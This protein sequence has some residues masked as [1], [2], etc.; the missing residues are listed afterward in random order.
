MISPDRNRRPEALLE[1]SS[2]AFS[3]AEAAALAKRL[4]GCDASATELGSERDQNFCLTAPDGSRQ[5]LKIANPAE[6]PESLRFENEAMQHIAAVAPGFPV[7]RI[8][9]ALDGEAMAAVEHAGRCC[10][11]RMISWLPGR[12]LRTVEPT[13]ALRRQLG[14]SLAELGLALRGFFHPAA[15]KELLWDI[16]HTGALG[17]WLEYVEDPATRLLCARVV[18]GFARSTL[19]KLATLRSQVIHNDFH[20]SNVLVSD[21]DPPTFAGAVDFGDM[22]HAPLVCDVAVGATYQSAAHGNPLDGVVDFVAGYHRV[23]PL[24][25]AEIDLIYELICARRATTVVVMSWQASRNPENSDYLLEDVVEAAASLEELSGMGRVEA[26]NILQRACRPTRAP[27]QQHASGD[28]EDL[29]ARRERLLGPA[30]RLFYEEPV[31]ITRGEGV[32]LYGADGRAY[33]DA[34]NNVP[35]VGHCHP[36]VVNA[37]CE[38][39]ATLNTHTRYLHTTVLDY[40]ERLL[41]IFPDALDRVMFSCTGTEANELALRIARA[42]S[43]NEGVIVSE[44]AYHGNSTAIAALSPSDEA[45]EGLPNWIETIPAPDTY[46]DGPNAGANFL[47]AMDAAIEQLAKRGI[48]PAAL[49]LDAGFTSDG[50]FVA[51]DGCLRSAAEKIRAA[52]GL[53]IADEV[54]SGFARLGVALWGFEAHG[55][56]PDIVTL[57]KPIGNG[58]PLAATITS[59]EIVREFASRGSYFNTFGGNPVSAAVGRAVLDAF[60]EDELEEN[61]RRVG[62]YLHERLAA[63]RD[64]H[65]VIGDV[66]GSGL[67][68]GVELVTDR[69]TRQPA[70]DKASQVV[71]D[72]RRHGVLISTEGPHGNV[73]KVRPPLPFQP[74]HVDQLVEALAKVI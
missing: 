15:K 65:D 38:Q 21:E 4:Y 7:P 2:P 5:L 67:F 39:A 58:H 46:R 61:S 54:Q 32:W 74:Q 14:A 24:E 55:F 40:A 70:S 41:S 52:G 47:A 9:P 16:R 35:L 12:L 73:L 49:L 57:G 30:Y 34:Y 29:I 50:M 1:S 36:K 48:K 69:A 13:P 28:S 8:I 60:Q 63:L 17:K 72:M 42:C 19:P 64:R 18:D 56:D 45:P 23:C 51:P 59:E 43:G 26:S 22:I 6:D 68:A 25:R 71:N 31:H 53:Y 27:Q 20:A 3:D 10:L 44:Y 66:R 33:L 62:E 11:V 37:L